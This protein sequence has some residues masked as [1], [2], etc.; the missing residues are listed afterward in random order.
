MAAARLQLVV[1]K[2][3]IVVTTWIGEL[4][5]NIYHAAAG[6]GRATDRKP[7]PLTT[8]PTSRLSNGHSAVVTAVEL[9][10]NRIRS[11]NQRFIRGSRKSAVY[12]RADPSDG[13]WSGRRP[14]MI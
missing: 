11:C 6:P 3:F 7:G 2:F 13:P 5:L 14:L 10:L 9:E 1:I 4:Q 12:S 8:R